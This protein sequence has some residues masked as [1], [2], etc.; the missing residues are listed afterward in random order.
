MYKSHVM[1]L[2][3]YMYKLLLKEGQKIEKPLNWIILTYIMYAIVI[4]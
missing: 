2:S 3:N 4:P 1:K